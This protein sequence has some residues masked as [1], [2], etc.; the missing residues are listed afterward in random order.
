MGDGVVGGSGVGAR[1]S[2]RCRAIAGSKRSPGTLARA[3]AHRPE[4]A[5]MSVDPRAADRVPTRD[6]GGVD[7]GT[8]RERLLAQDL[9]HVLRDDDRKSVPEFGGWR[10]RV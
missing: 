1:V 3:E 8:V 9:E 6:F 4:L 10:E 7:P 2:S 5:G